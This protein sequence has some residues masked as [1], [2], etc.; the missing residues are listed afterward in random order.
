MEYYL[1][2]YAPYMEYILLYVSYMKYHLL[3]YAPY[4]STNEITSGLC[5][6]LN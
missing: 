1:L 6:L 2:M 4:S 3:M 5:P